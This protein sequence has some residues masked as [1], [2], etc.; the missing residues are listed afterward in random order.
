MA[1]YRIQTCKARLWYVEDYLIPSMIKQG[2]DRNDITIYL[3]AD[4]E[5]CLLSRMKNFL[6]AD[7]DAWYLQDDVIISSDFKKRTEEVE[8][9]TIACG[10]VVVQQRSYTSIGMVPK[11]DMWYSFP[12]IRVPRSIANGCAQWYFEFVTH[13]SQ[14]RMWIREKKRDDSIF[15]I[16]VQDYCDQVKTVFHMKPNIVDH[17]DYLIGGSTIN[18][19][20]SY[21]AVSAYFNEPELIEELKVKLNEDKRC[22]IQC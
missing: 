17:V 6:Q 22:S 20:R 10:F 9:G 11:I 15:W 12:C 4:D 5:G 18:Q 2:I 8:D 14:Y 16:Y 7:S 21:Q 13:N 19:L 1:K 3:D